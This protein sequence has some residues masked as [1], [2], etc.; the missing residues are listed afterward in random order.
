ME[1]RLLDLWSEIVLR[2]DYERCAR[3]RSPRFGLEG[4]ERAV[5]RLGHPERA[6]PVLHVAGSKG[7]G[8]L[9]HFLERGLRAA[10]FRTGLYTSPHLVDWRER[11]QVDGQPAADTRLAD[12]FE[13]VLAAADP[14]ATFFDLI[15]AAAFETF[16]ASGVEIAL[17]EVGLG[18]R[19]DSTN[20]VRPLAAVVTSIEREHVEVLGSDLGGIAGEKAGI[21][22][23][24]AAL[25]RGDGLPAEA[26]A[27]IAARARACG[28]AS[29]AAPPG[30][31]AVPAAL[32]GHPLAHVRRSGALAAAMLAAL[33]P[34][35]FSAA[36]AFATLRA[37]DLEIAGRWE[38]RRLRDGRSAV[39]DV[40]HTANSLRAVLEAFRLEEPDPRARGV[41]LALREEKDPER[42]AAELG[43]RPAGERWWCCRAGS[44]PRSADPA[45]LAAAFGAT[46]LE[47]PDFPAGPGT[48]LVTGST[49]LVGALR[50]ATAPARVA[51]RLQA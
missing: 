34:P 22:K 45:R 41:L 48:L 19:S 38:R 23:P 4:M 11:I 32:R 3:S 28:A 46:A 31:R 16:R 33:P 43:P 6:Y 5:Q 12:A 7:K 35:Y 51:A 21:F 30:E 8:T 49:Y 2:T 29:R 18:G 26:L 15:T 37:E 39:L 44:H 1:N 17:V 10:G 13:R 40:A 20:V 9:C 14:E 27:V 47:E 42:L 36:S 25:W 50:S 24:Q